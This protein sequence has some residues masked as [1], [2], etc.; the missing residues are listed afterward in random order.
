[1]FNPVISVLT[2]V[3]AICLQILSNLANDYGDAK[4]G[5]DNPE[6]LGPK[7]MVQ[8]GMISSGQIKVGIIIFMLL[9]LLS[10]CTLLII[11]TKNIGY[12]GSMGLFLLGILAIAA[13]IAYTATKKPYGYRALGDVSV[14]IFFGLLAVAG[15]YYLQTGNLTPHLL[16]PAAGMGLLSTG[17]LNINNI[18]DL[19]AD[20]RANKRTIALHLG[21]R[22][23]K[24]YH[25]LLLILGLACFAYYMYQKN[26]SVYQ[27]LFLIPGILFI[28]N[29]L[30]VQKSHHPQEINPYLKQLVI[31]T[32]I[33]TISFGLGL[34]LF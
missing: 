1:M 33:F 2:F 13:A 4:H 21:I 31:S 12:T 3:T 20:E 8:S 10:G 11:S 29:G 25:W 17:V 7:R 9:S 15:S 26:A 18:R 6:R 14:F 22:N 19:E 5:A 28:I 24:L 23:A 30:G 27:Y 34:I 16:L 32:L